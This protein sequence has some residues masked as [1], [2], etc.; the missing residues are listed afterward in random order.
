MQLSASLLHLIETGA[1]QQELTIGQAISLFLQFKEQAVQSGEL[2]ARSYR[3]YKRT[4]ERLVE[5]WGGGRAVASLTPQ[6]FNNFRLQRLTTCN[7]VSVGKEITRVKTMFKWLVEMKHCSKPEMGPS[8][9]KPS[10]KVVRRIR[11]EAGKKQFSAEQIWRLID[12]SGVHMRAMILLAINTG[13]QN[14]DCE[15]ISVD[16]VLQGVET[17]W[18]D[19]PRAKTEVDRRCPL[20]NITR[21]ALR[22]SLDRRPASQLHNAFLRADGKPY[23]P[24]NNDLAIRFRVIRDHACI[25]EGGF[26]WLRKTFA[27]VGS[28]CGDQIAVNS[29]MGHVDPSISAVYRQ[30]V[31][32]ER[33]RLVA[34]C[35]RR[36]LGRK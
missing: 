13:F 20:W 33:L 25:R 2:A 34:G 23:S 36:W 30:E 22:R 28:G 15:S 10:A 27:T 4:S 16:V 12:E 8:F 18:L 17:G 14:T 9:N 35:V 32:D 26:S 21:S 6:D 1:E 5:L 19:F 11:R 31:Q 29:I 3:E 7:V 24:V